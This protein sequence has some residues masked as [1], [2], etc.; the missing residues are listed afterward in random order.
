MGDGKETDTGELATQLQ[1]NSPPLRVDKTNH[2][3]R[4]DYCGGTSSL[5][6]LACD[7]LSEWSKEGFT[8]VLDWLV[9]DWE[10]GARIS[11][12]ASACGESR[13]SLGN[14]RARS[15]AAARGRG[16][17]RVVV[18]KWGRGKTWSSAELFAALSDL[19]GPT[20]AARRVSVIEISVI[21]VTP[22]SQILYTRRYSI[23]SSD[24]DSYSSYGASIASS[25]L[26]SIK[27]PSFPPPFR[28]HVLR[29]ALPVRRKARAR[30]KGG[31]IDPSAGEMGSEC[32]ERR[33]GV[34]SLS[35]HE[36]LTAASVDSCER[37]AASRGG[38]PA[39][40]YYHHPSPPLMSPVDAHI[41]VTQCDNVVA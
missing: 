37:R 9:D 25:R 40:Y 31:E 28:G 26:S 18:E 10:I 6:L 3:I 8:P 39:I 17:G 15:G 11:S 36:L 4:A 33:K 7:D 16:R 41:P 14:V 27:F 21:G 34:G 29:V 19:D 20:Q 24:G 38:N 32:V 2:K 1:Q 22:Y 23:L 13:V 12:R 5:S 35:R 30:G